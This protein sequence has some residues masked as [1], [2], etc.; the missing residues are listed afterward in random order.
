MRSRSIAVRSR[1]D[2]SD[3]SQLR[4]VNFHTD[5]PEMHLSVVRGTLKGSHPPR[6][7]PLGKAQLRPTR[8]ASVEPSK[9]STP[10]AMDSAGQSPASSD[11]ISMWNSDRVP[12]L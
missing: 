11:A 12:R 5:Q 7:T 9:G 6:W 3:L 4:K 1:S 2:I 8:S 10:P